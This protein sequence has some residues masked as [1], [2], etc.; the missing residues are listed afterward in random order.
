[1]S[2]LREDIKAGIDSNTLWEYYS[3]GS[4]DLAEHEG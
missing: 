3:I 1:M 4:T 2:G